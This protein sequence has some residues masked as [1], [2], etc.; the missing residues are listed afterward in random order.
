MYHFVH[1]WEPESSLDEG[2]N[3]VTAHMT[4]SRVKTL[5]RSGAVRVLEVVHWSLRRDA[6]ECGVVIVQNSEMLSFALALVENVRRQVVWPCVRNQEVRDDEWP[7]MFE[8]NFC[9]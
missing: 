7:V 6:R 1:P 9:L 8:V 2:K 5:N 4:K 3:G